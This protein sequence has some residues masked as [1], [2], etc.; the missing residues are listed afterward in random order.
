MGVVENLGN[1]IQ[2]LRMLWMFRASTGSCR[3]GLSF[4]SHMLPSTYTLYST[5]PCSSN[6]CSTTPSGA[7]F[8]S[9]STK[10]C[11]HVTCSLAAVAFTLVHSG[12]H[13]LPAQHI[14]ENI[15]KL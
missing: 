12:Q 1:T 10:A 3:E 6:C 9:G 2:P 5:P 7:V 15:Q 11:V 8:V 13:I 4:T 14:F